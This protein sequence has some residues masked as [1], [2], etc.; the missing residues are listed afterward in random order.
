METETMVNNTEEVVEAVTENAGVGCKGLVIAGGV[1]AAAI[2]GYLVYRFVAKPLIKRIKA[3]K[4]QA[5]LEAW[6]DDETGKSEE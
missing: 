2:C 5:D 1:G 4:E 6:T 3:K